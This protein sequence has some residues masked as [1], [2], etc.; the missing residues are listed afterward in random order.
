MRGSRRE[1]RAGEVRRFRSISVRLTAVAL[2]ISICPLLCVSML[3]LWQIDGMI[4]NELTQSYQWLV[5]EHIGN[6]QDKLRL[7]D[8]SIS[9]TAMNTTIQDALTDASGNPYVLGYAISNEVFKMVPME[10][11]KEVYECLIYADG[12]SS[13][14]GSCVKTFTQLDEKSWLRCG[15]T[16]GDDCFFDVT[17]DGRDMMTFVKTIEHVDV[18]VF[19]AQR[20]G[21]IRL[22]LYLDGLFEP[23]ASGEKEYQVAL[24]N[25]DGECLYASD[26]GIGEVLTQW[27]AREAQEE[28]EVCHLGSYVA[29]EGEIPAYRLKL[30]YL[31]DNNELIS[32]KKQIKKSIYPVA[33]V[34]SLLIIVVARIY[35]TGFSRRVGQLVEKFRIAGSGD[36]SPTQPIRGADEIA[37]LD[38]QFGQ[39]LHDMDELNRRSA[40]QENAIR[41][42]KYRNLQ[43]QINPHFL[44]N[45]LE[46]ISAI[47]AMHGVMQICDLC[48]KL[49]DIFRYSLGKNEGKY[50]TVA[51]ELRQIQNYI[52]IQQVRH[53]FE[54]FYSIDVDAEEV[55]MLRFLLQ[56]IVENAVQHGLM[57][58]GGCGTLE[59]CIGQRDGDLEISIGDD[60]AGMTEQELD[61]LRRS[62]L[63]STDQRENISNV[64]VWNISQR[65][66]LSHGEPY[67]ITVQSKPGTGS[68]FT[69]RLP[70]ITKGMIEHDEIPTADRR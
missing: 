17:W 63:E 57:K 19:R 55:Y 50:T 1:A 3:L 35:F 22:D 65:I 29:L 53:K 44:Y 46:T 49:G 30:V 41:E 42:A 18:D 16:G 2:L 20:L 40:A 56:P 61:T 23:A 38:K 39:M 26:D 48:E 69:L 70:M 66:R 32:T 13:A 24:L 33:A 68:I 45:T 5:S 4:E 51:R 7:Y 37:V 11:R 64:G 21:Y 12:P 58:G 25:D 59:V 62:L 6:V 31:F 27:K 15:W 28:T 9:Y 43:L 14:Y 36:L 34:L 47:G 60:G 52:F 54:V 8:D 67:G 10:N